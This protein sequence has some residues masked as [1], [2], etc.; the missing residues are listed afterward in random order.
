MTTF[1]YDGQDIA[2]TITSGSTTYFVHGPGIDEHWA[3]V[4]GGAP[5]FVHVDGLGGGSTF[6]VDMLPVQGYAKGVTLGG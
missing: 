2:A 1:V 3:M 6:Q 4:Q 5:Y